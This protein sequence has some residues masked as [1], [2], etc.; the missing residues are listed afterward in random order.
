M[1]RPPPQPTCTIAGNR[2]RLLDTGPDRLDALVALIEGA[3]CSLRIIY[4]IYS[5]DAS[6]RRVRDAMLAAARRGVTVS[7][8]V[9]AF[10]SDAAEPAHFFA[11]LEAA[12]ASVCE[13]EPRLRRR[14]LMR[15]HQKNKLAAAAEQPRIIMRDR[16]KGV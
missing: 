7:L 10:G 13:F 9:D 3:R 6:G 8:I 4:Y 15:K 1:D 12:R 2:L 14:Y 16:Q 5:D 11:P